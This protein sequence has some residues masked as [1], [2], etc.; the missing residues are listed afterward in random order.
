MD[1]YITCKRYVDNE[2]KL[3]TQMFFYIQDFTSGKYGF[4]STCLEWKSFFTMI[5][6]INTTVGLICQ[7]NRISESSFLSNQPLN[8]LIQKI[9]TGLILGNFSSK[10]ISHF[11]LTSLGVY[12]NGVLLNFYLYFSNLWDPIY[13]ILIKYDSYFVKMKYGFFFIPQIR[14]KYFLSFLKKEK[15]N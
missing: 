10:I 7:I 4:N 6:L 11:M 12:L 15:Q 2:E 13:N 3:F 5:C 14:S 1:D 8:F 9:L